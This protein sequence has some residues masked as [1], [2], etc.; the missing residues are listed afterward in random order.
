MKPTTDLWLQPESAME[1]VPEILPVKD[2]GVLAQQIGETSLG[3]VRNS[4]E[5]SERLT[6]YEKGLHPELRTTS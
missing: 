2:T 5:M 4:L 6:L 1:K 3:H